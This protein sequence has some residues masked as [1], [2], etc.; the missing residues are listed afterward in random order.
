MSSTGEKVFVHL[1][2]Q[3]PEVDPSDNEKDW[4][5]TTC[6]SRDTTPDSFAALCTALFGAESVDLFSE[7]GTIISLS[8]IVN[9][10]SSFS[11]SVI[12][13]ISS[14][15]REEEEEE[16]EEEV[17][18][19]EHGIP[20]A[21][22]MKLQQS[23]IGILGANPG[24]EAAA[25]EMEE[26]VYTEAKDDVTEYG[27]LWSGLLSRLYADIPS[28]DEATSQTHGAPP[29]PRGFRDR[30]KLDPSFAVIFPLPSEY[31]NRSLTHTPKNALFSLTAESIHRLQWLRSATGLEQFSVTD[32]LK[33]FLSFCGRNHLERPTTPSQDMLDLATFTHAM[34]ALPQMR[35]AGD[36]KKPLMRL[37]SILFSYL[38][39][40]GNGL[41]DRD[42]LTSGLAVL[43][44]GD[45][46]TKLKLTFMLFDE[47]SDGY[48][49][50]EELFRYLRSLF[51]GCISLGMYVEMANEEGSLADL[52]A[53]ETATITLAV[54][55]CFR[56]SDTDFDGRLSLLEFQSWH[57][58]R[59]HRLS[60][61]AMLNSRE[62]ARGVKQPF[63]SMSRNVGKATSKG[64]KEMKKEMKKETVANGRERE[65][66]AEKEKK[67]EVKQVSHER[68]PSLSSLS[69]SS[70]DPPPPPFYHR[71][72]ATTSTANTSFAE[73]SPPTGPTVPPEV[74]T[75]YKFGFNAPDGSRVTFTTPDLEKVMSL[76]HESGL[77][78]MRP[79][80]MLKHFY[81]Y[82]NEEG[83]IDRDAFD[84]C[85]L[86]LERVQRM[87]PWQQ[88]RLL[89]SLGNLFAWFDRDGNGKVDFREFTSGLAILCRGSRSSKLHI[90]FDLADE[91]RDGFLSAG[92]LY[93]LMASL[94][95]GIVSSNSDAA[96]VD[97]DVVE[98]M[99]KATV[100][101]AVEECFADGDL[102]G[103]GRICFT[104]W[105]AWIQSEPPSITW[106]NALEIFE[107]AAYDHHYHPR[108]PPLFVPPP[109]P[110]RQAHT[111]EAPRY[112]TYVSTQQQQQ[113]HNHGNH[114]YASAPERGSRS[115]SF[116]AGA[117]NAP[118]RKQQPILPPKRQSGLRLSR[119]E[120]DDTN[121]DDADAAMLNAALARRRAAG[122]GRA[123]SVQSIPTAHR[124]ALPTLP[125]R[126]SSFRELP[127]PLSDNASEE[128]CAVSLYVGSSLSLSLT[129]EDLDEVVRVSKVF[130]SVT[131]LELWRV[132]RSHSEGGY[133][134][135]DSFT[136]AV[137]ELSSTA[138]GRCAYIAK[139]LF[140]S[141][142]LNHD[143]VV[144]F[145]DL[146]LS[147]ALYTNEDTRTKIQHAFSVFVLL[148]VSTSGDLTFPQVR[149]I[150]KQMLIGVAGA[151][152]EFRNRPIHEKNRLISKVSCNYLFIL[153]FC[154]CLNVV[155]LRFSYPSCFDLSSSLFPNGANPRCF[156]SSSLYLSRLSDSRP[157]NG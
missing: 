127:S 20:W 66:E 109:P 24:S 132:L 9:N 88:E 26:A 83:E 131:L 39:L 63:A 3:G 144:D 35:R 92:E 106:M 89:K 50:R 61:L 104:E 137:L 5:V 120:E 7:D 79:E 18:T 145:S 51:R 117:A 102:D 60:W 68:H 62:Y 43:C 153:Y 122:R 133:I 14:D 119:V 146:A 154:F 44:G 37:F 149:L 81:E 2:Y 143:G 93:R 141:C 30:Q 48:L 97:P 110:Q 77:G 136:E 25:A 130:S 125:T 47:D 121:N 126:G 16:E 52:E 64:K 54:D 4:Q 156:L 38:D 31:S 99:E 73:P 95:R 103:D 45:K 134:S 138:P 101:K 69:S 111:P 100:T 124:Q 84:R 34:L 74:E 29:S 139:R 155:F 1:Q 113:R 10:L 150:V 36:G 11:D 55:E 115:R 41:I 27:R 22:R 6:L 123:I 90:L 114:L 58:R 142:D 82:S 72:P 135:S 94:Y 91:D 56:E 140:E 128:R 17:E 59:P 76:R 152:I 116:T 96:S 21:S 98:A 107:V 80:E 32:L 42:E 33:H 19:A 28:T 151:S 23:I 71:S 49:N 86:H 8:D 46:E 57:N 12:T 78:M 118:R 112:S 40:D 15:E 129:D 108:H 65:R 67:R 85:V 53:V 75:E 105:E 13:V 148:N 147:L 157:D 70:H 87:F